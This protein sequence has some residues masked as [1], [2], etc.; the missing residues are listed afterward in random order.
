MSFGS[1]PKDRGH[2]PPG[3]GSGGNPTPPPLHPL[4]FRKSFQPELTARVR[5]LSGRGLPFCSRWKL[6]LIETQGEAKEWGSEAHVTMPE[7]AI[8]TNRQS[9]SYLIPGFEM[10]PRTPGKWLR[11]YLLN[12]ISTHYFCSCIS[13]IDLFL[14]I[15]LPLNET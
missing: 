13:Y 6:Q 5:K 15:L 10:P 11:A 7:D 14:K 9:A 3:V 4:P 2:R 8:S 1:S 12:M